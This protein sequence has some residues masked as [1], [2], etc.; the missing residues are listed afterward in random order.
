MDHGMFDGSHAGIENIPAT[1]ERL[2]DEASAILLSPGI[3]RQCTGYFG[4]RGAPLAI[5]RI[6]F[7]SVG[8]HQEIM[9]GCRMLQELGADCIK[10]FY[11]SRFAEP[12]SHVTI[13]I[14]G[15][16]AEKTPTDLAALDL[17]W[18]EVRDGARGVVFG[19]NVFQA[20]NPCQFLK[21]LGEIVRHGALPAE[22]VKKYAL[23]VPAETAN[24]P[25]HT[26]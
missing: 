13:P 18:R 24:E 19:R 22:V 8:F 23:T 4:R 21:A 14:L 1:L 25:S 9:I 20:S 11:T 17:A 5:A 7:N 16:G 3:L 6:N 10:T 2:G 15:L 12:T 26:V